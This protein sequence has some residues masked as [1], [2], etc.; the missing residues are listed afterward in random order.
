ME[1]G[2]QV[3]DSRHRVLPSLTRPI[4]LPAQ[5]I[6]IRPNM[7]LRRLPTPE[8]AED[9]TGEEG[10]PAACFGDLGGS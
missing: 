4:P 8:T 6:P 3:E 2:Y 1:R 5:F 9:R 7:M 10:G